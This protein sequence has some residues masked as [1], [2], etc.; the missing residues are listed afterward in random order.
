MVIFLD[1]PLFILTKLP[2]LEKKLFLK[3]I[4]PEIP[5]MLLV[6]L[7]SIDLKIKIES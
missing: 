5:L 4:V 6:D 3:F 1:F 7:F 2:F